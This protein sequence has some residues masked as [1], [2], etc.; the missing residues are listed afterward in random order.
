MEGGDGQFHHEQGQG[1]GKVQAGFDTF[2]MTGDMIIK[3]TPKL[4]PP[5]TRPKPSKSSSTGIHIGDHTSTSN[6]LQDLQKPSL[7]GTK[8]STVEAASGS[9]QFSGVPVELDIPPDDISSEDERYRI[10]TLEDLDVSNLPPPPAEFLDDFSEPCLPSLPSDTAGIEDGVPVW[11][12]SG[13]PSSAD[14]SENW[15]NSLDKAIA[16]LETQTTSPGT[17]TDHEVLSQR[18]HVEDCTRPCIVPITENMS[19]TVRA[20]SSGSLASAGAG[21]RASKSQ[22]NWLQRGDGGNGVALVSVDVDDSST[23]FEALHHDVPA[24]SC[25]DNLDA[26]LLQNKSDLQRQSDSEARHQNMSNVS[27]FLS[28]CAVEKQIVV[29]SVEKPV[30]DTDSKD[31]PTEPSAHYHDSPS[32]QHVVARGSDSVTEARRSSGQRLLGGGKSS[33]VRQP[34]PCQNG[35]GSAAEYN[36]HVPRS[37]N[38]VTD[39]S[40]SQPKDADHPS[41]CRL[42]KRLYHLDGFRKSDVCKHLSKKYTHVCFLVEVGYIR[43]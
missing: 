30:G 9:L 14:M 12:Q 8:E 42:A 26:L 40:R 24:S 19:S 1:D 16:Q 6:L 7:N 29:D 43:P 5:S 31:T 28:N 2:V 17:Q 41:A 3:T 35:G 33:P 37:W 23:S 32:P 22:E 4:A 34:P 20:N 27:R 11:Q 21:V 36:H 10:G 38:S 18:G 15:R 39:S 13:L 25:L